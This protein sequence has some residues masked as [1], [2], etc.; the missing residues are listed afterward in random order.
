MMPGNAKP[1]TLKIR[2]CDVAFVSLLR[3]IG[4]TDY[5]T[6][7][8]IGT[9]YFGLV[10]KQEFIENQENSNG[11]Y[12]FGSIDYDLS[13][14]EKSIKLTPKSKAKIINYIKSIK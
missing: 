2:V 12:M 7:A 10:F 1:D 8:K 5:K 6:D 4:Q 11:I 13:L 9:K 3:A 14:A